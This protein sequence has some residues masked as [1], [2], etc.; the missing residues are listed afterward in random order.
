[1]LAGLKEPRPEQLRV[2]T[3]YYFDTLLAS[4]DLTERFLRPLGGEDNCELNELDQTQSLD[5]PRHEPH[6]R[7]SSAD[8]SKNTRRSNSTNDHQNPSSQELSGGSSQQDA[9]YGK[10]NGVYHP[11]RRTRQLL[12]LEPDKIVKQHHAGSEHLHWSRFRSTF[13][14]PFSEFL[15][16]LVFTMIQQGGVAQTTLSVSVSTA[17]GGNGYGSYLTVPL[18]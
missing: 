17:P 14:E 2:L 1:M 13:Q 9:V 12:G 6:P 7:D 11:R 5:H 10:E 16:V 15:G 4:M 3:V 18:W 8:G